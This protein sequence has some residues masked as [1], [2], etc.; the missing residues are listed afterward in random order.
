[1]RT[2]AELY[3]N[4]DINGINI[5]VSNIEFLGGLNIINLSSI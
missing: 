2:K 5:I 3:N 1:M 4:Y